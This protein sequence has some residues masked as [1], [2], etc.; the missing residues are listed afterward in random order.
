MPLGTVAAALARAVRHRRAVRAGA[1]R[2]LA[3]RDLQHPRPPL[4]ALG[5]QEAGHPRQDRQDQ[6]GQDSL[7]RTAALVV[8]AWTSS[9]TVG[10]EPHRPGRSTWGWTCP[11]GVLARPVSRVR[12]IV[13]GSGMIRR[14]PV[15]GE[16]QPEAY[17]P[18]RLGNCHG[19]GPSSGD[20]VRSQTS[21]N[22]SARAGSAPPL[23]LAD[24]KPVRRSVHR[25]DAGAPPAVAGPQGARWC[26]APGERP[27]VALLATAAQA[28]REQRGARPSAARG[29]T[30][31]PVR[32][33]A[34]GSRV[35]PRRT[36]T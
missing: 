33:G 30:P 29:R 25:V 27:P 32:G 17:R 16:P 14:S 20:P 7:G 10:L 26:Q 28:P 13:H 3:R 34:L 23:V 8:V 35:R 31:R 12:L 6:R 4:A 2:R 19:C 11:Q 24:T 5:R 1:V 15:S 18:C 22:T 9:A 36:T 21:R